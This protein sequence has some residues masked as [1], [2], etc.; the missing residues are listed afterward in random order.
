M[1]AKDAVDEAGEYA[2]EAAVMGGSLEL[3]DF[4]GGEG[5]KGA[6]DPPQVDPKNLKPPVG[7]ALSKR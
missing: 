2:S 5:A 4:L 3:T 1:C 6:K 7:V